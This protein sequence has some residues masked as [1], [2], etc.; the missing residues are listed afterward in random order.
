MLTLINSLTV[1]S[2]SSGLSTSFLH[3]RT[4]LHT[5]EI[6]ILQRNLEN[7]REEREVSLSSCA[8]NITKE[9]ENRTQQILRLKQKI[10]QIDERVNSAQTAASGKKLQVPLLAIMAKLS[11]QLSNGFCYSKQY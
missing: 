2:G 9:R 5:D 8:G 6:E 3:N 4:K 11:A 1:I 10:D 7:E